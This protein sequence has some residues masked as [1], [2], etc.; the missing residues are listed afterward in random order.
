MS[1]EPVRHDPRLTTIV[2]DRRRLINIA[3]R[4]L[5]SV[6][7]A[8]DAVQETFT[9]WCALPLEQQESIES[10]SAWLST[11]VS[12]VCLDQL[13]SARA[14]RERYVGPWLPEPLPDT[15]EW[16][17]GQNATADP[18][19]RITLDESIDMAFLIV[20][21]SMTPAERVTFL[22]HDI[23]RY[24]FADIAEVVGRT[25]AAC[26]QLA[27]SARRRVR[28]AQPVETSAAQRADAVRGFRHAWEAKD[29]RALVELLDPRAMAVAD[30]GGVVLASLDPIEGREEVA[31]YFVE[32]AKRAQSLEL[33]ERTVNG[34]PGLV[35]IHES[36]I[37]AVYSFEIVDDLIHRIWVVRNPDKL[38]LWTEL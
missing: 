1:V 14:Q 28:A 34:R 31:R 8:E 20:L 32:L 24:P 29:V 37:A 5:G 16:S 23:F 35:A 38:H 18:A 25:P 7:E 11:V 10:P 13:G 17:R 15:A 3:Y 9:R 4:L 36:A 26:R 30:G 2:G 33:L 6:T 19:D 21:D 12:R 27:S 22:L